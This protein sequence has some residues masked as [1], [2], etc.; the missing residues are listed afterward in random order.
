[1]QLT[2]SLK[3]THDRDRVTLTTPRRGP[4]ERVVQNLASTNHPVMQVVARVPLMIV[5]LHLTMRTHP[6]VQGHR[7]S[8]G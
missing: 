1:M 3:V 4:T 7:L 2:F 6:A 5:S 8:K